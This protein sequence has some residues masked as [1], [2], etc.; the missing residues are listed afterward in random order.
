[1]SFVSSLHKAVLISHVFLPTMVLSLLICVWERSPIVSQRASDRP[2]LKMPGRVPQNKF[3]WIFSTPLCV[4]SQYSLSAGTKMHCIWH[5]CSQHGF[6][7]KW[8]FDLDFLLLSLI[9]MGSKSCTWSITSF[10]PFSHREVFK[11][12][13]NEQII[14]NF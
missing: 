5:I 1:M 4:R 14:Y 8:C 6:N 10:L 2:I 9:W 3:C 13:K 11:R 12:K 7:Y